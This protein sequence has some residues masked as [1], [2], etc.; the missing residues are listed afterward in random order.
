MGK[1]KTR[2]LLD[3]LPT[4]NAE[5]SFKRSRTVYSTVYS[6][7]NCHSIAPHADLQSKNPREWPGTPR[8]KP[9]TYLRIR[10]SP[11][12]KEIVG[13][14][15]G[16][17]RDSNETASDVDCQARIVKIVAASAANNSCRRQAAGDI[18]AGALESAP[19][20]WFRIGGLLCPM[21]T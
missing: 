5:I 4:C 19:G 10:L 12:C 8:Q 9:R 1:H 16:K 6:A 15:L 18:A 11:P 20:R 7:S 17:M 13:G 14:M 3:P 21:A 2:R